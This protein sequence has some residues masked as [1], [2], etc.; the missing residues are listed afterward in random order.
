MGYETRNIA[1]RLGLRWLA[2]EIAMLVAHPVMGEGSAV[3]AA[4]SRAGLRV[5]SQ[6]GVRLDYS[7]VGGH[8]TSREALVLKTQV[9]RALGGRSFSTSVLVEARAF[10]DGQQT[11][12]A[13]GM[14]D[15][16]RAPWT[17]TASPFFER[18]L[19]AAGGR[20]LYWGN[21]R[22]ELTP[23]QSLGFELY[24]SIETHKPTKWLLVYSAG[25]SKPLTVSVAIGAGVGPGP[26]L[27]T[28]T[29]VS[30]RLGAARR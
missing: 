24:G 3:N 12:I 2:F 29:I 1:L 25:V 15:Y 20:W 27:V 30:W 7:D 11:L 18:T 6:I 13:A 4:Q 17:M 8:G 22:R 5:A 19:Q 16:T 28:R 26:D 14:F 10:D 23:R 21:V 9:G